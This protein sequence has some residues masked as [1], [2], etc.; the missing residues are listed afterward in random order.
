MRPRKGLA[1]RLLR[2]W[3]VT[4]DV[5]QKERGQENIFRAPAPLGEG[6]AR[7]ERWA[8]DLSGG[9]KQEPRVSHLFSTSLRTLRRG[10][11]RI[12]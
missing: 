10:L 11:V 1:M 12:L 8:A 5:R 7:C 3:D 2:E 6:A 4:P 9:L